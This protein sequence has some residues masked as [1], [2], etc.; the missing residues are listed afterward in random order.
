MI[1]APLFDSTPTCQSKLSMLK[2]QR[3]YNAQSHNR[4]QDEKGNG[5]W[6]KVAAAPDAFRRFAQVDDF[7]V[8]ML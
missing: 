1:A 6:L 3:I 2:P 5:P 7:A 8:E 4:K